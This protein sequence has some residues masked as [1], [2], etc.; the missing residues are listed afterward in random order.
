VEAVDETKVNNGIIA[1][2]IPPSI[3]ARQ[4]AASAVGT[5]IGQ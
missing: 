1:E 4:Q 3:L 2:I 5:S